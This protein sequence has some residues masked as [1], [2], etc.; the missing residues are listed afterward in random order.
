M[1]GDAAHP[2]SPNLGQGACAAIEDA[3]VLSR[4]VSEEAD[5]ASALKRYEVARIPR[6]T[7][8]VELSARLGKWACW[9]HPAMAGLRSTLVRLTPA[10]LMRRELDW[11][12]DFD[13]GADA[14]AGCELP[15]Q[16]ER[17]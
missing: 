16:A 2:M 13:A 8:L 15:G 7:R 17:R 4:C 6:T 1:L 3:A 9:S 10:P 12:H 11:Q 14:L 5:I